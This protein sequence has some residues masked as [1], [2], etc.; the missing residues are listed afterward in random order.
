MAHLYTLLKMVIFHSYVSLPEGITYGEIFRKLCRFSSR[1][2]FYADFRFL[3]FL[4]VAFFMEKNPLLTIDFF[5]ATFRG[6][7]WLAEW[8][9]TIH[10]TQQISLDSFHNISLDSYHS[11][12]DYKVYIILGYNNRDSYE[13]AK[14]W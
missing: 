13:K 4:L 9:K 8:L 7:D 6:A 11:Q 2:H 10:R 1:N 12:M 3:G 5:S 14:F